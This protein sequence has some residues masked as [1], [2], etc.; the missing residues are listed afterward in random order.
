MFSCRPSSDGVAVEAAV[1]GVR[2]DRRRERDGARGELAVDELRRSARP[3][4]TARCWPTCTRTRRAATRWRRRRG[5]CP[6]TWRSLRPGDGDRADADSRRAGGAARPTATRAAEPVA[7]SRSFNDVPSLVMSA[8][9]TAAELSPARV[10][11]CEQTGVADEFTSEAQNRRALHE[12]HQA[13]RAHTRGDRAGRRQ[14]GER[15]APAQQGSSGKTARMIASCTVSMPRLNT[16]SDDSSV[17]EKA[18]SMPERRGEPE[19]VHEAE[20]EH[21]ASRVHA[22]AS[23]PSGPSRRLEV[24]GV[25]PRRQSRHR[26]RPA[27]TAIESAMTGS[28]IDAGTLTRPSAARMNVT[29]CATVKVVAASTISRRRRDPAISASRNRMWSI[30]RVEVLGAEAEELPVLLQ[31][32]SAAWRTTGARRRGWRCRTA[33]RGSYVTIVLVSRT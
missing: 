13:H 27:T 33:R 15:H 32:R 18:A 19:P 17:H 12:P 8:T 30:P 21:H 20:A 16:S 7:V 25:R 28:T 29:E 14:P 1:D 22:A 6:T 26:C 4:P 2:G 10:S 31:A 9:W 3:A 5:R 23:R 24:G 11:R